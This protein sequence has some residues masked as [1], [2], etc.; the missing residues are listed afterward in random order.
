MIGQKEAV[1]SAVIAILGTAFTPH[2]DKAL[3]L[4]TEDQIE[5]IKELMCHGITNGSIEYSKD[6]TDAKTVKTYARSM[7]M[8]HLKKTKILNGSTKIEPKQEE[9]LLDESVLPDDL[10]EYLCRLRPS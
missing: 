2:K 1:V 4:L 8:N 9:V 3:D 6:K 5:N 10:K 7:V